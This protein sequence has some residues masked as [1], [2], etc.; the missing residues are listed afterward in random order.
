MFRVSISDIY[1]QN[2]GKGGHAYS[3]YARALV[4]VS[5]CVFFFFIRVRVRFLTPIILE[6]PLVLF[7]QALIVEPVSN[8]RLSRV[9]LRRAGYVL[10]GPPN[11]DITGFVYIYTA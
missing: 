8:G 9:D 5:V 4:R 7:T 6:P 2:D 11:K 3:V 10:V 1:P